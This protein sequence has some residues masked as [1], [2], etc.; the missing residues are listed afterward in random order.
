MGLLLLVQP[1]G[2]DTDN[3]FLSIWHVFTVMDLI[4]T[5]S[6]EVSLVVLL[7]GACKLFRDSD[8]VSDE[9]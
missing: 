3:L 6:R 8:D 4:N 1:R 9:T 5:C 2:R 7:V